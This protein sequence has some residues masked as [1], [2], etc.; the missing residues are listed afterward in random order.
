MAESMT[1]SRPLATLNLVRVRIRAKVRV[2]VGRVRE[3]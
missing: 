2:R 3:A 1:S